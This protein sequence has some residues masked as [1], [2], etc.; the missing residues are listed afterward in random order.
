MSN[1]VQTTQAK[2]VSKTKSTKGAQFSI[3]NGNPAKAAGS[4]NLT[5]TMKS[6]DWRIVDPTVR[7]NIREARALRAFLNEALSED[8]DSAE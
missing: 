7:M 8:V 6:E 4:N 3:V 5:I 1:T 2:I